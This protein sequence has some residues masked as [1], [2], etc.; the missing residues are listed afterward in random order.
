MSFSSNICNSSISILPAVLA[1][2]QRRDR[3]Y[4]RVCSSHRQF[5]HNLRIFVGQWKETGNWLGG[6]G[7]FSPLSICLDSFPSKFR[8]LFQFAQGQDFFYSWKKE[9]RKFSRILFL[10][11][12]R[13]P[14]R[15]WVVPIKKRGTFCLLRFFYFLPSKKKWI[16]WAEKEEGKNFAWVTLTKK[17]L[18]FSF[19]WGSNRGE[20]RR[21]ETLA[22]RIRFRVLL[23]K[24]QVSLLFLFFF[25][26]CPKF[27]PK[28]RWR[29]KE[30]RKKRRR[31]GK[32][33]ETRVGRKWF[34]LVGAEVGKVRAFVWSWDLF[35][36]ETSCS[37]ES[38]KILFP[39][40]DPELWKCPLGLPSLSAPAKKRKKIAFLKPARV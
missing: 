35:P 7:I 2:K 28:S 10:K 15:R 30:K 8:R 22:T 18:S 1:P 4:R 21:R 5:W 3:R 13:T 16:K 11:C 6:S 17:I 9:G 12:I 31:E 40:S 33:G 23:R 14:A 39:Y 38:T 34:F 20:G 32:V 25:L 36:P 37:E 29:R 27:E 24:T 19:V 26:P